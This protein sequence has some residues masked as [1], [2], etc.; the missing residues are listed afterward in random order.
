MVVRFEQT[1]GKG[2]ITLEGEITLPHAEELRSALIKAIID[3]DE[4]AVVMENLE[5]IDLSCLQ[6]LCSAHRSAAR[7]NKPVVFSGSLPKVFKDMMS[8]AGFNRVTGCKLD[9]G[10]SCLWAAAGS[11]K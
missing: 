9:T 1:D 10:K 2:V 8:A 4:V 5:D 6:L 3:S 11:M 7:L